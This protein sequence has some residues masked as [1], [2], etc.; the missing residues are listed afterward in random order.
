V[1]ACLLTLVAFAGLASPEILLALMVMAGLASG[2]VHPS[3]LSLVADLV[4]GRLL[5]TAIPIDSLGY[6]IA[7][8]IGPA[9]G[10]VILL[11]AALSWVFLAN[12][13][14][15]TPLVVVLV[16]L[17]R[18]R[19]ASAEAPA[20][21][22]EPKSMWQDLKEGLV[23]VVREPRLAPIVL[24]LAVSSVFLRPVLDMLP[25]FTDTI[26]KAGPSELATLVSAY[27]IGSMTAGFSMTLRQGRGT[28]E[29]WHLSGALVAMVATLLFLQMD[30]IALAA[31]F[32][33]I[34]GGGMTVNSVAGQTILQ[35][36][37]QSAY[38][39]RVMSLYSMLFL[40]GPAIGSPLVGILAER[41]GLRHAF[42][43]GLAL[44]AIVWCFVVYTGLR[45]ARQQ[46]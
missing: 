26:L 46:R 11:H 38:R 40:G 42:D 30:H 19:H 10:G 20:P 37:A 23:Y 16:W 39:G 13:L 24:L 36:T 21:K 43:I 12:V 2:T 8:F 32:A 7:R 31:L 29:V 34:S 15:F 3:R 18:R 4:P 5:Q 17:I 45:L 27:G 6:N 1:Q 44:N 9:I 33:F 14:F 28:L 35:T 22:P 41:F 25:A